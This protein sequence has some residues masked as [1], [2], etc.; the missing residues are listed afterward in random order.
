M[1]ESSLITGPALFLGVTCIFCGCS[2]EQCRTSTGEVCTLNHETK[3]CSGYQCMRRK[4]GLRTVQ[5][6]PAAAAPPGERKPKIQR[7]RPGRRLSNF[8]RWFIR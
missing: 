1:P 4:L 6:T 3:C 5:P 8:D 7:R 2:G